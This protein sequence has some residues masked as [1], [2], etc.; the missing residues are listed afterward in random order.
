MATLAKNGVCIKNYWPS[1]LEL[2]FVPNILPVFQNFLLHSQHRVKLV[3]IIAQDAQSYSIVNFST[4][5]FPPIY[6]ADFG[7]ENRPLDPWP[8]EPWTLKP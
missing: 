3:S 6:S 1:Y 2:T 4:C 7:L 5:S 8:L